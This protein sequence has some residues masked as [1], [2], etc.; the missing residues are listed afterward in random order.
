M[1]QTH[2]ER[3]GLNEKTKFYGRI[4]GRKSTPFFKIIVLVIT[5]QYQNWK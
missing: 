4:L 1:D 3:E 5:G 2:E